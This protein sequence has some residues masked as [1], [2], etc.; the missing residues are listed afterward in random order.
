MITYAAMEVKPRR[1]AATGWIAAFLR[2]MPWRL[3]IGQG[4][5][6]AETV[7]VV[8]LVTSPSGAT[9]P[10]IDRLRRRRDMRIVTGTPADIIRRGRFRAPV[11][12]H[13]IV[14]DLGLGVDPSIRSAAALREHHPEA[15]VVI[16]GELDGPGTTARV[17][18]QMGAIGF[19]DPKWGV[20][21]CVREIHAAM[22]CGG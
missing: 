16:L 2:R 5:W 13:V 1:L 20:H 18:L 19:A 11:P 8:G 10:L 3:E 6:P 17:I 4:S 14:I 22:L 7:P 15:P 9:R 12:P 21:E